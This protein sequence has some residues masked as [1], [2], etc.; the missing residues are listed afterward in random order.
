M[1]ANAANENDQLGDFVRVILPRNLI[2]DFNA[3]AHDHQQRRAM[4]LQMRMRPFGLEADK[5]QAL[6]QG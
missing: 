3:V 5:N 2:A 1:N 6:K 4:E